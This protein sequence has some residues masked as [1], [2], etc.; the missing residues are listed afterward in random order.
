M[1]A[2]ETKQSQLLSFASKQCG[3]TTEGFI[4]RSD[5]N[6]EDLEG[7]AG[8]GIFDSFPINKETKFRVEYSSD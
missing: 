7:F 3:L 5:S 8:A 6:S 2:I 4:F 1:T